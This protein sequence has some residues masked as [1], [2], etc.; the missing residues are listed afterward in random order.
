MQSQQEMIIHNVD[1]FVMNR[2][3]IQKAEGDHWGLFRLGSV[4][5]L[6]LI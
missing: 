5:A 6:F 1:V 4:D 3:S 2:G